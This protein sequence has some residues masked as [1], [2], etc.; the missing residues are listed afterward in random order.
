MADEYLAIMDSNGNGEIEQTDTGFNDPDAIRAASAALVDMAD[1]Y[2]CS[3]R[4]KANTN[5]P[6]TNP[7]EII[8]TGVNDALSSFDRQSSARAMQAMDERIR[9]TL[10]LVA[11]APQCMFTQ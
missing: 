2:L 10:F 6:A 8:I 1:D 7:R 11:S 9:E 4:L 3:A 5:E